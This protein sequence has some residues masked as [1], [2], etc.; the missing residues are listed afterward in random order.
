MKK[1]MTMSFIILF[2]VLAVLSC[3]NFSYNALET[4]ENDKQTITIE[5]PEDITNEKFLEDID[6]ALGENN[7]DIMY[8][9]VDVTGKKPHYI[10]FKTNHTNNFIHGASLKS[11]FQISEEECIS[12]LTPMGYEVYPLYV[13]SV[14]QDISFYNW[15]DAAKYDLSSCTYYVKNDVC[16][17]SAGII[18]QLGYHV[19]INTDVFLSGKMP[20]L[21]F[22]FIPIFLLIMSMVFYVLANGKR[23]VIKKMDGYTLKSILL[24]EIKVCGF[25]FIGSFLIVELITKG[26]AFYLFKN[27]WLQYTVYTLA[28]VLV[29]VV[30][31]IVGGLI[32][33]LIILLQNK[34]EYVKGKVPKQGIYYLAMF[35]KCIF[36]AF[37]TFFMSIAIRNVRVCYDT[38]Q[39]SH[40]LAEKVREY[41]SVPIYENN[42]SSEG[43]DNNYLL[44][45]QETVREHNG[46]LIDA[47]NYEYNITTGSTL[48]EQYGQDYVSIN[49]NYLLFNPVYDVDGNQIMADS[50][51]KDKLNVLLPLTK[52]KETEKYEA[53]SSEAYSLEANVILYDDAISEIYS[54][55]ARVG[56]GN[57]GRIE[58]PVILALPD[59]LMSGIFIKSYCS[60]GSYFLKTK[61][62]DPYLE[63]QPILKKTGIDKVTPQTPYISSNFNEILDQQF[64]MLILYGSQT[65]I[66]SIGLLCLIIFTGKLYC[67]NYRER[68]ACRLFEGYTLELCM[69][70]HFVLTFVNYIVSMLAIYVIGKM[71]NMT[72]NGYIPV[73]TLVLDIIC[74]IILCKK[75]TMKNLH[76]VLKGAE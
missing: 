58:S 39:T 76:E 62:D 57:F 8:R 34:A 53:F 51:N 35:A 28:Y 60:K 70:K 10:Y 15:A 6:K 43:L 37:I 14:F 3:I 27:A 56:T 54:Y 50:F 26:I 9:Y 59:E 2:S 44:F 32:S 36:I 64:Q 66:L 48:C 49:Y 38:F 29:G 31:F 16:S 69:Q 4:I 52:Q 40:F 45:Y 75:Y 24:D 47:S 5:K 23:N 7:A 11:D 68:L 55:N 18:S 73:F 74:T 12:T 20:V 25:N 19:I 42:A 67:E 30:T 72:I 22:A 21:L 33:S 71:V 1:L 46:I 13:S 63:L 65:L 61:T 41:V 17:E